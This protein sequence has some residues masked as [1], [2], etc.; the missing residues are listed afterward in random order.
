MNNSSNDNS[1]LVLGGGGSTGNAWLIGVIAGLVDSGLDVTDADLIVGTSAGATAA[2]QIAGANPMTLL[3]SALSAVPPPRTSPS[4][5]VVDLLERSKRIIAS[6]TD[7]ADMRRRMGAAAIE[8]DA[9]SDGDWTE[10][11]RA[12]VAPRLPRHD[13]PDRDILITAIDAETGEPVVF[14]RGSG[15]DLVDAIASSTSSGSPYSIGS[16]RYL[17]G[18]YRRNE[19]A[20]LAAGYDRVL[21][22]SPFGGRS[23]HPVEWGMDLAAQV[24]ELSA[25]G[26]VVETVFPGSDS[27]HLFGTNAMD[28]TLRPTAAQAG[29]D[30]GRVLAPQLSEFW[31]RI[32]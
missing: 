21:V 19:N 8:R 29:Y 22:L 13:W 27:E 23:L 4:G 1:A 16:R 3:A 32:L 20:D 9:A 15:V 17:D 18:G 25:G 10:R 14:D 30:L 28:P 24:D 7:A 2:A 12:M 11:W 6:A 5:P 31:T 26:S